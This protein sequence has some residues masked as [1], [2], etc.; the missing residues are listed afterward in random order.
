MSTV[1]FTDRVV[2]V[3]SGGRGLGVAYSREV[4]RRGRSRSG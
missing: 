2:I 3:T 1:S 4:A